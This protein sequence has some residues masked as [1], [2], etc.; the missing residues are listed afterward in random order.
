MNTGFQG[1]DELKLAHR[2]AMVMSAVRVFCTLAQHDVTIMHAAG[3]TGE[4][5]ALLA[6]A[7]KH[8]ML[9][10][11]GKRFSVLMDKIIQHRNHMPRIYDAQEQQLLNC[12]ME[13]YP[14]A[15]E[16]AKAGA[17]AA[18]RYRSDTMAH[19]VM[20]AAADLDDAET[21][22]DALDEFSAK[23]WNCIDEWC[24]FQPSGPFQTIIHNMVLN[25]ES[26]VNDE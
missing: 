21:T 2:D 14:A 25:A 8:Q 10:G 9:C 5:R 19:T 6:N 15:L 20:R 17:S 3:I 22:E 4:P 12:I 16:A 18:K 23:L 24:E 13:S 11:H 1:E 26:S 7:V